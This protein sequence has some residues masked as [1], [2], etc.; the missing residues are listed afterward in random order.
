[1]VTVFHDMTH[2]EIEVYIDDMVAKYQTEEEH[3][4]NL[5]KLF[6]RSRKF[7]LMLNPNKFTFWVRSDKFLGFIVSKRGIKVDPGNVKAIQVMP[8]NRE[9]VCGFLGRLNYNSK[10]ISHL[11]A[12]CEP[13][14]K[15]LR[16]DQTIVWNENCQNALRRSRSI[17]KSL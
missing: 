15:L 14:F 7:M 10:F 2:K 12:T 9:K 16:K 11:T 6:E 4:V 5:E 8:G 1:M 13:I 17:C 3:L